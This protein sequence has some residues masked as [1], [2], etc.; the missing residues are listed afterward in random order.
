MLQTLDRVSERWREAVDAI[1]GYEVVEDGKIF[2]TSFLDSFVFSS[3][4]SRA[5]DLLRSMMARSEGRPVHHVLPGKE[6]ETGFGPAYCIEAREEVPDL[7]PD[8]NQ[9]RE[10]L[11]EEFR[12]LSGVGAVTERRLKGRGYHSILDLRDHRRFG[13]GAREFLRLLDQAGTGPLA[14]WISRWYPR[15][16]PLALAPCGLHRRD[17]LVFLDIET[18]GIFSRPIILIGIGRLAGSTLVTSQ[19]LVR[20]ISEE[21][22]ALNAAL[23]D[24]TGEGA[25]YISFNGKS[26]DIPYISERAAYYGMPVRLDRPHFD[27]LHFSRRRWGGALPDCRLSTLER[28]IFGISRKVDI[29]GTLVPEFYE[30]FLRTG[31]CGPLVPIVEHNRQDLVTLGFLLSTLLEDLHARS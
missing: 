25:A 23:E 22:A 2:R 14:G 31:N 4:H 10:R 18:L 8:R 30:A 7:H 24:L 29:P 20:E 26:F 13:S 3:E 9:V 1:P 15:S 19:Y 12:L 28:Q 11:L 5:L 21:P 16:H 6:V 17:E 27:L